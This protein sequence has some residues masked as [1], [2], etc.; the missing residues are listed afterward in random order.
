MQEFDFEGPDRKAQ[1][2]ANA[3]SML[4]N[5]D[6]ILLN[7]AKLVLDKVYD[8]IGLNRIA[9]DTLRQLVVARLCQPI[10]KMA[11]VDYLKSHFHEDV[12]LSKNYLG[13]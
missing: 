7:G 8:S 11:I 4:N 13:V 12:G 3:E 5:I 9:D 10:I 6:S 2:L 1:E